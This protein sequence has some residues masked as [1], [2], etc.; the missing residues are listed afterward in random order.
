MNNWKVQATKQTPAIDFNL[1]NNSLSL[2]GE[3]Y[4]ENISEFA[5]PL[6][7]Q[8]D[9]YLS[10]LLSTVIFTIN[11]ELVYFNSSSSKM[12]LNLFDR[13][14]RES[15]EHGRQI[16]INWIYDEENDSMQEYGQEFQEDLSSI[17]FNLVQK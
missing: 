16:V 14:E 11:I 12:L 9:N 15:S 2:V 13:L 6:F 8:L 4:P 7:S 1:D 5:S 3:C 10:Q 17:R